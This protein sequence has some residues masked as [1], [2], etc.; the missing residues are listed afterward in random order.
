[1]LKNYVETCLCGYSLI[2]EE[3]DTGTCPEC[4]RS[5]TIGQ[6]WINWEEMQIEE[7][8]TEDASVIQPN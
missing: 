4:E 6:A 1:M 5:N 7:T 3:V 8:K 2:Q